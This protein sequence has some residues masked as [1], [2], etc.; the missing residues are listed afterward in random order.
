MNAREMH[1]LN[2]Y[3]A[4]L[5]LTLPVLASAQPVTP[6]PTLDASHAAWVGERIFA[7]ECNSQVSCLTSWNAG[8]DF[9]SLGIGHFIWYR[10]G[11]QE[12]FVESFP[13]LL[14]FYREQGVVLPAWIDRLPQT[15]SPWQTRAQFQ[16]AVDSDALRELRAFLDDTRHVQVA[17]IIQRMEQSLPALLA[18]TPR[19][20]Q[21]E[22]LFRQIAAEQPLGPYALIDYINFKGEGIAPTERYAGQGWGLLQVLEHMLDHPDEQPL[23]TRFSQAAGAV[24]TR[25]IA[26]APPERGEQRWQNGWLNRVQ[27]YAALHNN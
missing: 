15:D 8:E 21:I 6:L 19:P 20:R 3:L 9:P 22:A 7:N 13:Q 25:R 18:A 23:M 17:F 4:C 11:Q 24:L 27:T 14:A 26:N 5:L 10:Q 12:A 2:R 16:Q 1:P